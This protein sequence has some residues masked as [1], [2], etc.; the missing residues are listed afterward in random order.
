MEDN[1]LVSIVIP[2]YNGS[3]YLK[4][5]IDSALS[6]T[7]SNYEVIVVNDG[8][9]DNGETE[10]IALSYGN[11][12]RYFKKSNGGVASALNLGIKEMRGEYFSWLSHD[13]MYYPNK[14]E[15]QINALKSCKGMKKIVY[16][17]YDLLEQEN[18][19][20]TH[21][22]LSDIYPV[23]KLENSV[24][25]VL[26]ILVHGCAML[27]HKSHF[28]RVGTFNE[29]LITT[30]DYD[31]WFRMFR[32]QRLLYI[33]KSL[34]I[35]RLHNEQGTNTIK[36]VPKERQELHF[37]FVDKLTDEEMTLMYGSEYNFYSKMAAFFK[38]AN[39]DFAFLETNKKF[40]SS[41]I[42]DNFFSQIKG[43]REYLTN[44]SNGK[45]KKIC[46]FG[47]GEWGIRLYYELRNRLIN[48][49]YFCDNNPEKY[50]Y[51]IDNRECISFDRL[52]EEKDD[53]LVIISIKTATET[54]KKQLID[55]DFKFF[56]SK[57]EIDKNFF[58]VP[59][60]KWM[61][62]LDDIIGIDYSSDEVRMLISRFKD[63][64]FDI[65]RFYEDKIK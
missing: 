4:E 40:H 14:L 57:Q 39:M 18:N 1:P 38:G 31:L 64:I 10:K 53:V 25:P 49:D 12:I 59:P 51:L 35:S 60:V 28:E 30:Q 22:Y 26:Q 13:D 20:L 23:E 5:A 8:S 62:S 44:L 33:P 52:K 16:T 17:D 21:V 46:I 47:A 41:K 65:C 50:G 42:P 7:Y 54:I 63:T 37:S 9:S 29:K 24:F 58:D 43:F 55:S 45:A 3:N 19:N 15:V 11:K 61:S 27:I 48:V 2:V 36:C 32:G 56:I 34:T 6:Q